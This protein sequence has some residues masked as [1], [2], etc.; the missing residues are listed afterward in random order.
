MWFCVAQINLDSLRMCSSINH[1]HSMGSVAFQYKFPR[2][3]LWCIQFQG[4]FKK[5][6]ALPE[7]HLNGQDLDK[8]I[9]S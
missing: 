3:D 1:I 8:V 6:I 4:R 5:M 9:S 7:S 2:N